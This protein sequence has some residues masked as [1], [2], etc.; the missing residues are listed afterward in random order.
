[1][2]KHSAPSDKPQNL[3]APT[4]VGIVPPMPGGEENLLPVGAWQFP[5]RIV[6][7]WWEDP[8][9]LP[10]YADVVQL[11][12]NGDEANPVAEKR[13]DGSNYPNP[14]PDLWLDVPPSRLEE[15]IHTLYYLLKPWNGS[16]PQPSA[17]VTITIDKTAPVLATSSKLIFPPAVLPPNKLDARYLEQNGDQVK[18]NLPAYT[19]PKPWDRITWFYGTTPGT[20]NQGGFIEL[21]ERNYAEPVVITIEGQFLRD[22]GK[23][24]RYVRYEV[25]DRAGNKSLSSDVVELDVDAMPIPR[26]FLPSKVKEASGGANSGVVKPGDLVAGATVIIPSG[27]IFYAGER[28][29]V[30]WA[31]RGTVGEFRTEVP[32]ATEPR[33]CKIP[34]TNIAQHMGKSLPVRYEV[35]ERPDSEEPLKS[36]LYTLRVEELTGLPTVQC[37]KVSGGNLSLASLT[38]GFADFT[39]ERWTFMATDQF[40]T[41]TVEGIDASNEKLVIPVLTESPVRQVAQVIPVGRISKVNLQRFKLNVGIDV[42]VK[43]SFDNKLTWKT[44]PMLQPKLIA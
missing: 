44:F 9:S 35:F 17:P 1:M 23:G 8:S 6:F 19:T 15:G 12:W 11:I 36:Q 20:T 16:T 24:H 13:Y 28:V 25:Q 37:E 30:Q 3:P 18:V 41:V 42:K 27:A 14:P 31:A 2:P 39:L 7:D 22:K 32:V 26:T 5:L 33:E 29:F 4:V 21:D 10:M 38:T 34:N 40:I 43:V